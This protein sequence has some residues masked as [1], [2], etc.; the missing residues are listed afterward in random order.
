M[1]T[2]RKTVSRGTPELLA[3][4][5]VGLA[6]LAWPLLLRSA[7]APA[8]AQSDYRVLALTNV[9]ESAPS[10]DGPWSEVNVYWLPVRQDSS[11]KFFRSKMFTSTDIQ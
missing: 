5:L 9:I 7:G 11:R 6:I 8:P 2:M 4:L 1:Q 10:M 3:A